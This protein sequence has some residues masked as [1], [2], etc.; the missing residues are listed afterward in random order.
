MKLTHQQRHLTL[1]AH[2]TRLRL[3]IHPK[4]D[5]LPLQLFVVEFGDFEGL[6]GRIEAT[7]GALLSNEMR[8]RQ[9]IQRTYQDQGSHD[10]RQLK[11]EVGIE[12][13]QLLQR[14]SLIV[15]RR[16]K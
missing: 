10:L 8:L 11:R 9:Y 14:N 5:L 7:V 16:H 13:L 6:L 12:I 4:S 1:G 2:L 3:E 15:I